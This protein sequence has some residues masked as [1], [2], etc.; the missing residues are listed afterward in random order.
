M[1]VTYNCDANTWLGL[2]KLLFRWRGSVWKAILSDV[3]VWAFAYVGIN[4]FLR[5]LCNDAQQSNFTLFQ[6]ALTERMRGYPMVFMIGFF[7]NV[8]FNR[9]VTIF[10]FIGF[11]DNTAL[12]VAAGIRGTDKETR[13][14]K[15]NIIRYCVLSQ[16]LAFRDISITARRR[17]PEVESLLDCGLMTPTEYD[18]YEARPL[19][20][21]K[22]WL[23]IH[24]ALNLVVL[25]R[26]QG[27]IQADMICWQVQ[28]KIREFRNN[29]HKL[30]CFDFCPVPLVY[31]QIIY[32]AV[33]C[34]FGLTL[35]SAQTLGNDSFPL[36]NLPI[37]P[38]IEFV[39]IDGWV[40]VSGVL[41]QPFGDDDDDFEVNAIID[42]NLTTGLAIVDQTTMPPVDHPDAFWALSVPQ[43]L[44]VANAP[45]VSAPARPYAGSV[46][47]LDMSRI[48]ND[49]HYK[50]NRE[51]QRTLIRQMTSVNDSPISR[52]GFVDGLSHRFNSPS[53]R[54]S[55]L[56]TPTL[57]GGRL[58]H[59][60]HLS[61]LCEVLEELSR[62][63]SSSSL[64]QQEERDKEAAHESLQ[65]RY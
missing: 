5:H 52:G 33:R 31:P 39:L 17:F 27:K 59:F 9:W 20:I 44:D 43:P 63:P 13:V 34:F 2:S 22:S 4:L 10:Q 42:R 51:R 54:H 50:L 38:L 30:S 25:A 58:P 24:W 15:R 49:P 11:I 62:Q 26:E 21:S 60:H 45:K 8:V 37:V 1:T 35:I 29:L 41:I 19:P 16:A 32:L 40:N 61:S 12:A 57:E 7:T 53:A 64:S 48:V 18:L 47:D 28:E 3:V 6:K 65:Q 36:L 14:L 23:P 46:A 55:Q 56:P